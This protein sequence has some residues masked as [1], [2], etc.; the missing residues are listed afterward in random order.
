MI[1]IQQLCHAFQILRAWE[2]KSEASFRQ[3]L[4]RT[5]AMMKPKAK[6]AVLTLLISRPADQ[7]TRDT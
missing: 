3:V 4:P 5:F 1:Y 2:G 6:Q 7:H